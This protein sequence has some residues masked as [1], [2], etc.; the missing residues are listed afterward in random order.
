MVNSARRKVVAVARRRSAGDQ[1][2]GAGE[3]VRDHGQGEPGGVGHEPP[4][5]QVR[6]P[7]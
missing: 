6:Q 2:D 1:A 4:G 7:G 3:V 5:G